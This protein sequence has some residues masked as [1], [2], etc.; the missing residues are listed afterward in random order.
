[1]RNARAVGRMGLGGFGAAGVGMLVGLMVYWLGSDLIPRSAEKKQEVIHEKHQKLSKK[2]WERVGALVFLCL[3]NIAFWAI[4]EQQG[5]T[6]QL[7][8]D[9]RTDWYS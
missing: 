8:A 7:W 4:Y 3:L 2:D 6:L 9:E 5:N 1:M